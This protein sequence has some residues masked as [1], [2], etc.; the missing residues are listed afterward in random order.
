MHQGC[1]SS[2]YLP[3]LVICCL[4]IIVIL[5]GVR[6]SLILVPMYISLMIRAVT[7]PNCIP[8]NCVLKGSEPLGHHRGL[9]WIYLL[10]AVIHIH[11]ITLTLEFY[12]YLWYSSVVVNG[13]KWALACLT[14]LKQKRL[15]CFVIS[16][17]VVSS[18]L[19]YLYVR[20]GEWGK[21]LLTTCFVQDTVM[22][23]GSLSLHFDCKYA[24]KLNPEESWLIC[25][26]LKARFGT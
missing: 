12:F 14:G 9:C 7:A 24:H 10:A 22:K 19:Y 20:W 5:T 2:T 4:F 23:S 11:E 8:T 3:T 16:S 6:W 15:K 17:F 18:F 1:L 26:F 13:E 21:Y 25:C